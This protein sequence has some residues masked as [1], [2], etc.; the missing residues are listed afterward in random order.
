MIDAIKSRGWLR[1]MV[2]AFVIGWHMAIV[3]D[4]LRNPELRERNDAIRR[5]ADAAIRRRRFARVPAAQCVE[6]GA[7]IGT[8][9]H[10]GRCGGSGSCRPDWRGWR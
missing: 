2:D 5:R 8:N 1:T 10:C 9:G 6:T 7:W 4:E 3:D